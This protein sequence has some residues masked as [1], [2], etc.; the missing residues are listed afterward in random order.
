[1]ELYWEGVDITERDCL[2]LTLDFASQW[3]EWAPKT[4]DTVELRD[5]DYSTGK[6]YMT[7]VIPER[8]QYRVLASSA[9]LAAGRKA[10]GSYKETT[11]GS[12]LSICAAESRMGG[13]LYG[14][15]GGLSYDYVVR[16][17]EGAAAFLKRLLAWEGA[18]IRAHNGTL[19]GVSI[20]Y[21]QGRAPEAT[22]E[23]ESKQEGVTYRRH[24]GFKW[25]GLTVQTPFAKAIARDA[26]AEG[27]N[28]PTVTSLPAMNNAQAGRWAR[29]LLLMHNRLA[30]EL[31]IEQELRT[32]I[33]SLSRI[34]ITGDTDMRGEWI[35]D[36]V[37]HDFLGGRTTATV[38]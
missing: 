21:A 31:T 28:A 5:G 16:R 15:S 10:W 26:G 22:I 33:N 37:E 3:Y 13:R 17:N 14:V 35:A 19:Q 24:E 20:L 30:E 11:L 8:H 9:R 2:E 12:L 6:L 23:I 34:E 38:A 36:E 1:M 32:D 25:T 18:A 29:G 7:A 27:N 4:E